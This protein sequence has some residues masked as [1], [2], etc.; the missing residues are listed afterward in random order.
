L[1]KK[2]METVAN[3]IEVLTQYFQ[4]ESS[5]V[6][7]FL[8]GSRAKGSEG[9]VSDWDIA[10]YLKPKEY[11]EIE[12][13]REYLG[14]NKIW[15]DLIELLETD[16]VDFVVLNRARPSLVYNALRTGTP[17][18]IRDRR[19]YLD[20]LCKVSYEAVEWWDFVSDFW[21]ISQ[22]AKSLP[23]EERARVLEYLR[24]LENEFSEMDRIKKFSWQDYIQDSF[25]RKVIE[26]W[27]ENLVMCALDIAKVILASEKREIPQTYKDT[28]K[29]FGTLYVDPSFAEKFSE[30]ASLRNILVH[31]YLDIKWRRI[32]NFIDQAERLYPIFI[33]KIKEMA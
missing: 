31:E 3:K 15:S 5:V 33:K 20:L 8:F 4:K 2:D 25:K 27:V 18:I 26:R 1:L 6:L 28:L 10:V 23:P 29:I 12:T 24:F 9:G 21:K 17:L 11:L 32:R 19:L 30:F 16:D 13:E 14:E 7:A 22:K